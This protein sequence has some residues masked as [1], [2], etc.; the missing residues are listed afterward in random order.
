MKKI[1]TEKEDIGKIIS[2]YRKYYKNYSEKSLEK[3]IKTILKK[4][5]KVDAVTLDYYLRPEYVGG[6]GFGVKESVIKK[7]ELRKLVR[8]ELKQLSE[9]INTGDTVKVNQSKLKSWID[10]QGFA[11]THRLRIIRQELK[12]GHG[13]LTVGNIK[14]DMVEV[15]ATPISR[16]VL[17][18]LY[19]PL[20]I[21]EKA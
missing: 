11:G 3:A 5:G 17:G 1:L 18:G 15:Y 14:D 19:V 13:T 21:L 4:N 12:Y 16:I 2:A 9:G 20:N 8:E 6:L 7:S 10:K